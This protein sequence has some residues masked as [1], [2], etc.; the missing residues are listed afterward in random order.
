[1]KILFCTNKFQEVSN[2]P[3]KFANLILEINQHYPEH[4]IRILTE[5]VKESSDKVYRLDLRY[6]RYLAMFSHLF[7]MGQYHQIAMQIRKADFNFDVLVYNNSFIGLW[8]ALNGIP[9]VGMIN[10][11]NNASRNWGN[12]R[13]S[14]AFLK[15]FLF[16]QL[17]RWSVNAH[18]KIITNSLYL[19]E[20][21]KKVYPNLPTK[22]F[23]LY[24]SIEPPEKIKPFNYSLTSHTCIKILFVKADYHRGGLSTLIQALGRLAPYRFELTII[25]PSVNAF[26]EIRLWAR[27]FGNISLNLMGVQ[28]QAFV[29]QQ[30][31]EVDIFCVPSLREALGVANLE[32]LARG[33]PVVSTQVGGI[34]EVLDQGRAGWMAMPNDPEDLARQIQQCIEASDARLMKVQHGLNHAAQFY[35]ESMFSRFLTILK[36]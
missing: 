23:L 32:A 31:M 10:D 35:P 5:D 15:Q 1:M 17:E 2:G 14:Y 25:G 11:D 26:E 29:F 33:V 16:K 8:S 30:L 12:F 9:T 20:F 36:G 4:E 19:T 28:S 24:K 13:F 21:L 27:H 34:P 7:R 6:P 22:V 3:A 18:Q